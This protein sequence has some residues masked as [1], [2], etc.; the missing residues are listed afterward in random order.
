MGCVA[1]QRHA[2]Q[3]L[4]RAAENLGLEQVLGSEVVAV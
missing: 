3:G 1:N 2:S 4:L